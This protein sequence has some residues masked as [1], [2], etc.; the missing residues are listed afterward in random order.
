MHYMPWFQAKPTNKDW[1]WHWTMGKTNPDLVVNGKRQ[2]AAHFTPSIGPYDSSDPDVIEYHVQL[3]KLAGVDGVLLDWYGNVDCMDY[4]QIHKAATKFI[5]VAT[6]AKLTFALVYEDR[7]VP[8]L[9]KEGKFSKDRAESQ[10]NTLLRWL[11]A[12]WFKKPNYVRI[13][14]RPLFMVFGPEYYKG[15][16][17]NAV[18]DGLSPRPYFLTLDSKQGPADG[19]FG[20]PQPKGSWRSNLESYLARSKDLP[21]QIPPAF[22]RFHDYYQDAGLHDSWGRIEDESGKTF[23][24]TLDRALGDPSPFVQLVT[25][26]DWGEGTQIEPSVELGTRDLEILQGV[27][28]RLSP[29]FRA[30]TSDLRLPK[31]LFDLRKNGAKD[32]TKLDRAS[33]LLLAGDAVGARKLIEELEGVRR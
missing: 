29:G 5:D 21:F 13:E 33:Q 15:E 17:W 1:G 11:Q 10:G 7:T 26:N 12:D 22:P 28:K 25:W 20:W 9:I 3:M 18:F 19:A 2:I 6:R 4:G 8:N 16:A 27:R 30:T 24:E 31:R 23:R 14:G 32:K